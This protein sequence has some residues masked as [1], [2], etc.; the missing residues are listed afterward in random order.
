MLINTSL[1]VNY[2][3][4][5]WFFY[6]TLSKFIQNVIQTFYSTIERYLP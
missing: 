6:L 5:F 4:C 2:D 3:K 1:G